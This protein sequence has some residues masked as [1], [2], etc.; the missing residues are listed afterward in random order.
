M[1]M[2]NFTWRDQLKSF[3]IVLQDFIDK[4]ISL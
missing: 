2:E 1:N 4:V 3:R